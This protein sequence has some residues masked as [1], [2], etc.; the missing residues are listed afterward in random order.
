M[1]VCTIMLQRSMIGPA[2]CLPVGMLAVFGGHHVAATQ[3][4]DPQ[5]HV[6]GAVGC[7]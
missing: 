3:R 7:D 2:L 1:D 6:L 5:T 4:L